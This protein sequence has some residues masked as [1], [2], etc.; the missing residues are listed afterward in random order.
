MNTPTVKRRLGFLSELAEVP[1]PKYA[2]SKKGGKGSS[3]SWLK[4]Q[5]PNTP[6]VKR[7]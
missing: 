2:N 3:L 4:I 7:G 1:K 5:N 6:T